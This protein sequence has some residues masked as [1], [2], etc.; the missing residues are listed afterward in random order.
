LGYAIS[1]ESQKQQIQAILAHPDHQAYVAVRQ[2]QI[3]GYIHVVSMLRLT[4]SPFW[5]ICGLVVAEKE[6]QQGVGRMLVEHIE[7]NAFGCSKIRVRCNRKRAVAHQFYQKMS[8]LEKKE[9]KVFERDLN[10]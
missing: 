1:P 10:R 7:K 4:T 2:D 3:I 8:Y 6:R 5:E 9:Q